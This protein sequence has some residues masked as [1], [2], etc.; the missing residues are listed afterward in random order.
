MRRGA[1]NEPH[2]A[3]AGGW[4]TLATALNRASVD[5]EE[6]TKLAEQ[7]DAGVALRRLGSL[8]EAHGLDGILEGLRPPPPDALGGSARDA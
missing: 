3:L 8:A 7:L 5:P 2:P 1:L 4:T 6:L